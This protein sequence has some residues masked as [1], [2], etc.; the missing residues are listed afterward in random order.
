MPEHVIWIAI[1]QKHLNKIAR[2]WTIFSIFVQKLTV[3]MI[4][5]AYTLISIINFND[6][7]ATLT[8]MLFISADKQNYF[9]FSVAS[10]SLE[11][12]MNDVAETSETNKL[13]MCRTMMRTSVIVLNASLAI[14]L[15]GA[16]VCMSFGIYAH[17]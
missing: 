10:K 13:C 3:L 15:L 5:G 16:L 2:S 11:N 9:Y 4:I 1:E 8:P 17:Y 14:I 6:T 7:P 12:C